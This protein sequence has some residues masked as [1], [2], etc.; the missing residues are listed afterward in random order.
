MVLEGTFGFLF[1]GGYWWVC[2]TSWRENETKESQSSLRCM[3]R[4]ALSS[5]WTLN[6]ALRLWCHLLQRAVG[7][8]IS[9]PGPHVHSHL[10][11]E[12]HDGH[13]PVH[14]SKPLR[15]GFFH[16]IIINGKCKAAVGNIKQVH[17]PLIK[18]L[19]KALTYCSRWQHGW[20]LRWQLIYALPLPK[21]Y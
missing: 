8:T 12:G 17:S 19:L 20:G 11:A 2:R 18:Y 5:V 1:W 16:L 6:A 21:Y 4:W 13:T 9:R 14:G 15:A 10:D 7:R 3:K